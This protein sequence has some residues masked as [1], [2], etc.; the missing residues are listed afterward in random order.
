MTD[1]FNAVYQIYKSYG[2][3]PKAQKVDKEKENVLNVFN[4]LM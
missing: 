2:N 1:K 4:K 3:K